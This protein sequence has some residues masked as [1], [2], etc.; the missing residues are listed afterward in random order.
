MDNLQNQRS[1]VIKL[2][3]LRAINRASG[4]LLAENIVHRDIN[5]HVSPAVLL[6]E[7]RGELI[8]LEQMG[9]IVVVAAGIGGARKIQLTDAGRAQVAANL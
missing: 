7:F 8:D 3:I 6:S 2:E 1:A 4:F 5:L 9:L